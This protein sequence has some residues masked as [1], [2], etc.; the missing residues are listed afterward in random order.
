MPFCLTLKMCCLEF[1]HG[2]ETNFRATSSYMIYET[3]NPASLSLKIITF[4]NGWV[5]IK[6]IKHE[7][8]NLDIKET[9]TS[10][11]FNFYV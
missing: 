9:V 1:P 2:N 10:I 11:F 5:L 6:S 8:Q 7:L 4:I 3:S